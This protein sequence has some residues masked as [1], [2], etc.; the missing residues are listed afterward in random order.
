MMTWAIKGSRWC[1][2]A[3]VSMFIPLHGASG[4]DSSPAR[5]SLP[6]WDCSRFSGFRLSLSGPALASLHSITR[7]YN[8]MF[9]KSIGTWVCHLS[10]QLIICEPCTPP[11]HRWPSVDRRGSQGQKG[12]LKNPLIP[13]SLTASFPD[14][15]DRQWNC[16][17]IYLTGEA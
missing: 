8:T 1:S 14:A 16:F 11:H 7:Y 4:S 3:G 5:L 15:S 13:E 9:L 2:G 17:W 12:K 6:V 10:S